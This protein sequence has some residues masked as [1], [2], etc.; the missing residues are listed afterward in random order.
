M[1]ALNIS[2]KRKFV[3]DGVF[4]SELNELFSRQLAADGYAGLEVRITAARTEIVIKATRTQDVLGEKGQRIRELTSLVQKR[5]V[6]I[7]MKFYCGG[8]S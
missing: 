2:K 6:Y 8:K 3:A 7:M 1:S 4:Y 5:S